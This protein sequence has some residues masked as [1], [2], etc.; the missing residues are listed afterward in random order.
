MNT[1]ACKGAHV[2]REAAFTLIELLVVIAIIAILA[3][4]LLPALARAKDKAHDTRC[5]NNLKQL[6]IAV[7]MY[8]DEHESKLP[9][10]EP[11]PS[12]PLTNPPMA[13]IS[14]ILARYLDYNTNAMPTTLTVFRCTKDTG[15]PAW[16]EIYFD[17]EGASYQWEFNLTLRGRRLDSLTDKSVLM[18]DY[19][20]FHAGGPAGT[21]FGLFGDGH[22]ARF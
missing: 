14:H 7:W 16:P 20:N 15:P 12:M 3:S 19:Q 10:A 4:L 1:P 8:A 5:I 21:R 9:D 18:Y 6:G 22:A 2:R 17:V 11:L 13:R